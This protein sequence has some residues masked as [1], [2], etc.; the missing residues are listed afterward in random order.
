MVGTLGIHIIRVMQ[1][2]KIWCVAKHFPG[3]GKA[4]VDPHKAEVVIKA[5]FQELEAV[6]LL[7]FSMTIQA[8]VTGI[9]TSHGIYQAIDP[10]NPATFSKAVHDILRQRL[11]F[12]GI[13]VTDDLLMGAI[14]SKYSVEEASLKAIQ[15]GADLLLI[16]RDGGKQKSLFRTLSYQNGLDEETVKRL[17]RSVANINSLLDFIKENFRYPD[18]KEIKDYFHL[19]I[20]L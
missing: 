9:M 13:I 10:E 3:L 18:L 12:D 14:T 16:S 8:G 19:P 6:D 1:S 20:Y 17:C 2:N 11:G 4:E 7:P 5:A 15:G